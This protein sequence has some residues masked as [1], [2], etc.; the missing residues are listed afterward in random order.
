[1]MIYRSLWCIN[2]W[3]MTDHESTFL[4]DPL[5]GC[6]LAIRCCPHLPTSLLVA[7]PSRGCAAERGWGVG[8]RSCRMMF[9][10]QQRKHA[11]MMQLPTWLNSKITATNGKVHSG[12]SASTSSGSPK[13]W[14]PCVEWIH[15]L[16]LIFALTGADTMWPQNEA[17]YSFWG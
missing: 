5:F 4:L 13:E 11:G 2:V 1:M 15:V 14:V 17:A 7:Q 12:C 10:L 3:H 6:W 16:A 8:F 9:R